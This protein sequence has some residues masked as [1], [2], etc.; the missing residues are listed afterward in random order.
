[1]ETIKADVQAKAKH[2]AKFYAEVT[3]ETL[4]PL[5]TGPVPQTEA[6][7]K[8]HADKVVEAIAMVFSDA[9]SEHY[10]LIS[11]LR[12]ALLPFAMWGRGI[13]QVDQADTF[14]FEAL[15]MHGCTCEHDVTAGDFAVAVQTMKDTEHAAE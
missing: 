5:F 10:F 14:S 15:D 12:K 9:L 1:M 2:D 4:M 11:H 6:D 8:A 7:A 3:L 13:E